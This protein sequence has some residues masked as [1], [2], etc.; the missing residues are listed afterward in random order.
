MQITVN[1]RQSLFDIMIQECGGIE[2]ILSV[3]LRNG[4]SVTDDLRIGQQIEIDSRE[5][6]RKQVISYLAARNIKP[7][8][9]LTQ[10][11]ADISPGGIGSMAVEIDFIVS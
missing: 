5:I 3:A 8:T 11:S 1:S 7:A 10:V 6:T 4:I 2:N 9:A